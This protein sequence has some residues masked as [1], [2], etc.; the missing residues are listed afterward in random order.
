MYLNSQ[1]RLNSFLKA[2]VFSYVKVIFISVQLFVFSYVYC[3]MQTLAA[4]AFG[5]AFCGGEAF[6]GAF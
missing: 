3:S 5:G 6:G 2:F 4:E 1:E